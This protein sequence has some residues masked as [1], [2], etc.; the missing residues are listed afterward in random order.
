MDSVEAP[1]T[2]H[3]SVLDPPTGIDAGLASNEAIVGAEASGVT[4]TVAV[5]DLVES[6]TLVPRTW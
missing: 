4:V 1:T 3:V 6:A 5:P 2:D